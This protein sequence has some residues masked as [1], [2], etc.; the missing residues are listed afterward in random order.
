M[1]W[2]NK[3]IFG[4]A[5]FIL[6][7]VGAGVYMVTKDSDTLIDDNYYENSLDYDKVYD[8]KQNLLNDNAKPKITIKNDTLYVQFVSTNNKGT[9]MFKRPSD[10]KLDKKIL[11]LTLKSEYQL[12]VSS[13]TKGNWLLEISWEQAGKTYY[14]DQPIYIQ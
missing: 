8:S 2:G 12:P 9:L 3:I 1:N 6:F 7:I 5:S 14:H 10:G 4:L 11:F 13:F